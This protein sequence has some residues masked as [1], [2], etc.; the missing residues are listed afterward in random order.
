LE[1][2]GGGGPAGGPAGSEAL[3]A[4]LL[5]A[6]SALVATRAETPPSMRAKLAAHLADTG[7]VRAAA[8]CLASRLSCQ[9]TEPAAVNFRVVGLCAS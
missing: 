8:A 4:T 5:R 9:P 6:L 1:A 2:H 3:R 7:A